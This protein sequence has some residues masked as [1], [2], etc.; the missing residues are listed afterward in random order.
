MDEAARWRRPEY[1]GVADAKCVEQARKARKERKRGIVV[2]S[3]ETEK[4]ISKRCLDG[5]GRT[6]ASAAPFYILHIWASDVEIH[7]LILKV[8]V[9][10]WRGFGQ[11]VCRSMRT[12]SYLTCEM[13]R[14][15][16][17]EDKR[18]QG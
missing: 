15:L 1:L 18:D 6:A 7:T 9:V 8:L 11:M 16:Q 17:I 2:L 5:K 3:H 14:Y 10:P 12:F 13:G 4:C